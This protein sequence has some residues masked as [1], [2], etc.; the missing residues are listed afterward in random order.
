MGACI[1]LPLLAE[2]FRQIGAGKFARTGRVMLT[3]LARRPGTRAIR[4]L[5]AGAQLTTKHLLTPIVA[6]GDDAATDLIYGK[7][8]ATEP[9]NQL[10]Q[11][12]RL[13]SIR[14]TGTADAWFQARSTAGSAERFQWEGKTPFGLSSPRDMGKLLEKMEKGE[15]VSKSAA[16]DMLRIMRGQVSSSRI[17]W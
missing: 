13:N 8:G 3:A 15:A 6:A 16:D 11:S 2:A 1:K 10:M 5:D 4:S 14:A 17:P 9:V 7:V 12:W